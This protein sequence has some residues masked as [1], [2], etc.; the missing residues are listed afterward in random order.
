MSDQEPGEPDR[1]DGL[2]LPDLGGLLEQ[3]GQMQQQLAAA[4]AEAEEAVV[5]GSAGGG[6]VRVSV[7]GGGEFRDIT[8]QPDAVDPRDV[9]MLEDLV[10]AALNDAMGQVEELRRKAAGSIDLGGL[11][12]GGLLG[13]PG[14][15]DPE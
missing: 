1:L 2:Q 4:Q 9:A 3:A 14:P 8:I 12:L 7:T 15:G 6:V 11:D 10:L 13:G 5:E